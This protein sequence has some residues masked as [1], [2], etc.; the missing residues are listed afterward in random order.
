MKIFLEGGGNSADMRAEF[1]EGLSSFLKKAGLKDRMP[2]LVACGGRRDAYEDFCFEVK[3]KKPA[4][5]LV[6][7]EDAVIK[8]ATPIED[9]GQWLPWKHLG[10]KDD[11]WKQPEDSE[12][13]QCH[14]MVE[15][16]ENWFLAD[17]AALKEF[18]GQ[19]FKDIELSDKRCIEYIPKEDV[20]KKLADASKNCKTKGQYEKGKH[21][22]KLLAQIDPDIVQRLS[23]WA[24]RFIDTLKRKMK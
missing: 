3:Q 4:M 2:K 15:C 21:S 9:F 8:D 24:R 6:D 12:D 17:M 22:F 20:Y 1:R 18:F 19:G 5:L 16:M 14:L 10:R 11:S 7:S 13:W 23:P